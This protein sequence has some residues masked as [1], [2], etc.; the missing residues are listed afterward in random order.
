MDPRPVADIAVSD[1]STVSVL[2]P[3]LSV[4]VLPVEETVPAPA[5]VIDV[6][7]NAMVSMLSTP[8]KA[9]AEVTLRPVD[10]REKSP[11][12][13]PI[14]V[15]DPATDERVVCP[16]EVRSVK[17]AVPG[18]DV[19]IDV[20]FA[21]PVAD[22]FQFASVRDTSAEVLPRV[23]APVYE[24][25]PILVADEPDVLMLVVPVSVAPPV[26]VKRPAT[27]TVSLPK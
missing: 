1:E 5:N 18:A 12:A 21:A 20:K 10:V 23:S 16:H 24:P 13:L 27:D 25:V 11:V 26:A 14:T 15:S 2:L 17:V 8:V 7:S 3:E 9:P 22:I 6:A 4:R 19:P